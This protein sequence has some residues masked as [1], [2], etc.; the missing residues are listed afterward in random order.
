VWRALVW[1]LMIVLAVHARSLW[2]GFLVYD[3]GAHLSNNPLFQQPG[4]HTLARVWSAPFEGLYAPWSY[5]LWWCL[6]QLSVVLTGGL[7]PRV[8]HA[9]NWLLHAA[10]CGLVF[11]VCVRRGASALCAALGALCFGLHPLAVESVAWVSELR[12]LWS[13]L[14][15]LWALLLLERRALSLLC[16]ALA[17]LAKPAAVAWLPIAWLLDERPWRQR[18]G[19]YLPWLALAL[20]AILIARSGQT[21]ETLTYLPSW[22]E[23]GWIALD[24]LAHYARAFVWPLEL[25]VD[26]G[27]NPSFVLHSAHG[28]W[29]VPGLALWAAWIWRAGWKWPLVSLSALLPVLGWLPFAFQ[30]TSTVADRYAY[31][32][33][34]GPALCVARIESR[35][36][37]GVLLVLLAFW[38]GCSVRQQ[39]YWRDD[40]ALFGRV[41]ELQPRSVVAHNNLGL[42]CLRSGRVSEAE[43]HWRTA[44]ELRPED[45]R[46]RANLGLCLFQRGAHE[47]GL[48]ELG[49]ARAREPRYLRAQANLVRGLAQL[50]RLEQAEREVQSLV[51]RHPESAEAWTLCGQVA[52]ARGRREQARAAAERALELI[53][54]YAEALA[55]LARSGRGGG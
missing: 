46:A 17:L 30:N 33:L 52:L 6:A 28:W 13:A 3:D 41:L 20:G 45:V 23:R 31:V 34:L 27:R 37:R 49:A 29:V 42:V 8:F 54:G 39:G 47:E 44:L 43:Q 5:T 24:A 26:P 10:V 16:F 7:D 1:T 2:G 21:E 38:A 18:L 35:W 14:W 4:L 11:A 48:R 12:G 36:W 15:G 9:A 25:C 50:G 32:A 55:L 40:E 22:P 53:P 51:E 19:S